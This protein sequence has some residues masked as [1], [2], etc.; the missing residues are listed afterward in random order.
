MRWRQ[1]GLPS[2]VLLM[3]AI[4]A[5]AGGP[6][7]SKRSEAPSRVLPLESLA[8]QKREVA[9]FVL[10]KATVSAKGP[11]ET[12][13]GNPDHYLYF[14]AHPDRAVTAWRRLG[15]KCVS[16]TARGQDQFGW[17]DDQGSDLTWETILDAPGLRI[18]YADGKVRPGTLMPLIP[19]RG[20]VIVRYGFTKNAEG[21]TAITHQIE[22]FAHTDSKTAA[23]MT[24][25]LGPSST[26]MGEQGL[27]QMQMFFSALTGYLDRHPEDVE[28][29]FKAGE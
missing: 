27:G 14:L 18:W 6:L 19:V 15:A 13:P 16:I 1:L 12:F 9:K 24:R 11:A 21:G 2:I 26:R 25:L 4:G 23:A 28:K 29:L 10:D 7:T 8:P 22:L 5:N 17:S 3:Q 20:L